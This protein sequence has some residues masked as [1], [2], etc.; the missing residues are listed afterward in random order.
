MHT[1]RN[2]KEKKVFFV[3]TMKTR[4]F[5]NLFLSP[6]FITICYLALKLTSKSYID[7]IYT[8]KF[9]RPPVR[10]LQT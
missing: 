9:F 4:L 3:A 5:K 1:T 10:V 7:K 2:Y 6:D 8:K